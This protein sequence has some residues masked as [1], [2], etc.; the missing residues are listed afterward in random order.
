VLAWAA[1]DLLI[2]LVTGGILVAAGLLK[3]VSEE[4]WQQVWLASYRLLPRP[5]VRPVART[6]PGIEVACGLAVALGVFGRLAPIAAAV[7][8]TTL[9]IAVASALARHLDIACGC[10]GY[11][12][13]VVSWRIVARNL[14][15][16]LAVAAT[17]IPD[18]PVPASLTALSWPVQAG[19]LGFACAAVHG[20]A[21]AQRARRR[22]RILSSIAARQLQSL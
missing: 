21:A 17:A 6:L 9:A 13:S 19:A 7:L 5:L 8:L 20:L 3:L 12:T 14:L 18:R 22:R 10:F 2:R 16:A 15:I 1:T 4:T 11:L